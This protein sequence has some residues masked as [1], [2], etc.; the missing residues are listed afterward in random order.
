[1][2]HLYI[3]YIYCSNT[4]KCYFETAESSAYIKIMFK[5]AGLIVLKDLDK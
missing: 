2:M 5:T 1:M 3:S 4:N